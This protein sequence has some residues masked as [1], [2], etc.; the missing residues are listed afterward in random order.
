MSGTVEMVCFASKEAL[1]I[2][3]HDPDKTPAFRNINMQGAKVAIEEVS[4]F[5]R[6]DRF[7]VEKSP[8]SILKSRKQGP[9]IPRSDARPIY[10]PLTVH[11]IRERILP[12][13]EGTGGK[14]APHERRRHFRTF[15]AERYRA[16]KGQT[17]VIPATWIGPSE[18]TKGR[19]HYRICLEV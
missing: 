16:M 17:I 4:Y 5:N 8:C 15:K 12:V 9:K 7:V 3:P 18:I 14:K 1:A 13:G 6:P 2:P 10:T 11:E 19:H